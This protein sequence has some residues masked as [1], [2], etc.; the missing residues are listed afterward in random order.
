MSWN[1][2]SI[3]NW[4]ILALLLVLLIVGLGA[5]SQHLHSVQ[6]DDTRTA[7][8]GELRTQL[9]ADAGSIRGNWLRTLNP[10]VKTVQGDVV[11]N[12]TQQ[13]G[14]M[15]FVDLPKPKAGTFYQLWLYD[16][17]GTSSE[18]V[19][20]GIV[21]QGA[22]NDELLALIKSP[23]AVNEPYKFEFKL[24]TATQADAGKVLLMMQ[25]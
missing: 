2:T 9:L 10:L 18:P 22:G 25:P 7:G 23:Q 14:V 20:G 12:S 1:D 17:R 3:K 6:A 11:W 24:H 16:A 15:R 19:S 4:L 13:Q 21:T 5:A 8:L